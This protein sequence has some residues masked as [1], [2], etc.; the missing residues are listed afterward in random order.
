MN[1]RILWLPETL[2]KFT[3]EW[4]QLEKSHQREV[5]DG[6]DGMDRMLRTDPM[7]SGESRETHSRRVLF[8]PPILVKYWVELRL[9]T[10]TIYQAEILKI[11]N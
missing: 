4:E 7:T 10:V 1:Y 11:R 8:H 5:L 3:T 6:L 9:Q 2:A